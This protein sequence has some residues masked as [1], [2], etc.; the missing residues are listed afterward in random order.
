MTASEAGF[1]D[2]NN[3]LFTS[4]GIP[5]VYYGS[6]IAFRAGAPEHGGNRDYFGQER[7]EAAKLSDLRNS[8][9][10]IATLRRDSPALQRGLQV[11]LD[12]TD[13]TAAFYRVY[14]HDGNHQ[15]ALVML[16][17]GETGQSMQVDRWLSAGTWIDADSGEAIVIDDYSG[18]LTA[19][20]PAHDVRVF[21]LNNPVDHPGLAVELERLHRG[22]RALETRR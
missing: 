4:R 21:L 2:A 1:R 6:E 19:R 22:A 10:R 13:E 18:S 17:K 3:W 5:V 14:Q 9:K 20:V 16:N 7:I 11:L 12:F 8:L 15:T